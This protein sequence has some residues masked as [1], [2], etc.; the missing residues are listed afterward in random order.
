MR[1]TTP[2]WPDGVDHVTGNQIVTPGN[3]RLTRR[4]TAEGSAF[5]QEFWTRGPM[6]RS[7]HAATPKQGFVGGVYDCIYFLRRDVSRHN[8]NLHGCN[9]PRLSILRQHDTVC[10]HR[11]TSHY[12]QG[13][14]EV[15]PSNPFAFRDII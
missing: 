15:A 14:T 5:P 13:E 8:L 7:V 6:D 10:H 11:L 12:R 3:A 9:V 4:A 1:A 2:D